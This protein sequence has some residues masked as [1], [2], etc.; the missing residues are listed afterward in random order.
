M[1]NGVDKNLVRLAIACASFRE[2]HGEW[3]TEARLAPIV[4]WD[5]GQLLDADNFELLC[6]RLHIRVT[7]HAHIAVGTANAHIVYE[8]MEHSAEPR[9]VE[10]AWAWLSVRIRPELEHLD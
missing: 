7:R 2:R 5:Y 4:L 1:P 6:S 10:E 8:T 3:P 9:L